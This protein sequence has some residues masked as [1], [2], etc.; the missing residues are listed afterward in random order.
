M[1]WKALQN[2]DREDLTKMAVAIE[3]DPSLSEAEK[4]AA[5]E[6]FWQRYVEA[7]SRAS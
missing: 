5:R 7:V 1:S 2:Q 4:Q 3:E 6:E